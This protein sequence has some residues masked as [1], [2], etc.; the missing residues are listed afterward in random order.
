MRWVAAIAALFLAAT[1]A[2]AV[3][4]A[5]NFI[6]ANG[7]G[8]DITSLSI[9]HFGRGD[10]RTLPLAPAAGKRTPVDFRD[11]E[12]AFDIRATL[13]GGI[14]VVWTGVNLCEVKV[15]TLNRNAQGVIWVDYE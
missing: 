11:P 10:W 12:C 14:S 5:S 4:G 1:P 9:R 13:A 7:T 2:V 15:V 3:V 6:L 8:L